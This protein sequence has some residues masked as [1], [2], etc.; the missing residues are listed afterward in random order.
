MAILMTE[1][2][3][4]NSYYSVARYTGGVEING[5]TYSIVDKFGN[6]ARE[7]SLR[8]PEGQ[9]KI[10]PPGEPC[11]LVQDKW[12]PIYKLLGRNKFIEYLQNT[13]Y[14]TIEDAKSFAKL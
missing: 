8:A 6:T 12:I 13:K 10:I 14:P 3:W 2:Y 5:I 9:E 4:A 11:D 1:E 7:L